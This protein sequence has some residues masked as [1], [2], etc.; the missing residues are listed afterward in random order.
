MN[1]IWNRFG[2][3]P[4]MYATQL[5][6]DTWWHSIRSWAR[7]LGRIFSLRCSGSTWGHQMKKE[8]R[9]WWMLTLMIRWWFDNRQ[10]VRYFC[11]SRFRWSLFL[12]VSSCSSRLL[13]PW[14]QAFLHRHRLRPASG[15]GLYRMDQMS[16]ISKSKSNL[17]KQCYQQSGRCRKEKIHIIMFL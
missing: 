3:S 1:C 6:K 16:R 2:K 13:S 4:E 11:C 8:K 15:S 12:A 5:L 7:L 17:L 9:S 14:Q 10:G